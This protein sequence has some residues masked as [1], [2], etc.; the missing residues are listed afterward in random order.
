MS[1]VR[2]KLLLELTHLPELWVKNTGKRPLAT[3][4]TALSVEGNPPPL[5]ER[6]RSRG[7]QAKA[8]N[9]LPGTRPPSP[10]GDFPTS[11]LENFDDSNKLD[12]EKYA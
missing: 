9:S 5:S 8:M 7:Y 1:F 3:K 4:I 11:G 2:Y 10:A 12:E 6:I